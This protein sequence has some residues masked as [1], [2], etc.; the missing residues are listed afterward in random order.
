M[1]G[2]T[3][4]IL[5]GTEMMLLM[6]RE[7]KASSPAPASLRSQIIC[8]AMVN[9]IAPTSAAEYNPMKSGKRKAKDA[10]FSAAKIP[11]ISPH[12][13]EQIETA[14]RTQSM[15]LSSSEKDK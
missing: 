5:F 1:A 6:S 10:I 4:T 2:C 13:Q 12:I 8:I 7:R 3:A 14:P 11:R 15:V 9:P